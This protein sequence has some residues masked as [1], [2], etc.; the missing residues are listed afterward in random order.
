MVYVR[1]KTMWQYKVITR[2]LAQGPNEEELNALGKDGSELA[3][4][5]PHVG[6]AHFYFKRVK[7]L[8]ISTIADDKEA[9]SGTIL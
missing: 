8:G 9:L 3:A 5:L 7:D 6:V 4:V 1:D 2:D